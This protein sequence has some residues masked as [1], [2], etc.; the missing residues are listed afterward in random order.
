MSGG[1]LPKPKLQDFDIE[2]FIAYITQGD[3]I[4]DARAKCN[5]SPTQLVYLLADYPEFSVRFQQ[6]RAHGLDEMAE[7]IM[8]I[9]E[10]EIDVR[11]ADVRIKATQWYLSKRRAAIY[12]DRL[13]LEVR[14][15]VDIGGALSE[16]LSRAIPQRI[17]TIELN[18]IQ[19]T[20]SKPV[21]VDDAPSE[22]VESFDRLL[23]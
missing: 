23:E 12:G 16:A 6:A 17:E 4:A 11:R 9:A 20:G 13:E 8:S 10:S 22:Q 7:N 18:P 15:T 5:I 21:E 14:N 3:R 2:R 1:A 19:L